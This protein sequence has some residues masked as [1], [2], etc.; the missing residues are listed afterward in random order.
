M[1][2]LQ[3]NGTTFFATLF[4]TVIDNRLQLTHYADPQNRDSQAAVPGGME[5]SREDVEGHLKNGPV[6]I[7]VKDNE[8]GLFH[9]SLLA[10]L[11]QLGCN[12]ATYLPLF[13]A[14]ELHGVMLICARD[15]QTL[16]DDVIK[17]FEQTIQWASNATA[18]KSSK[19]E[20]VDSRSS[21]ELKALNTL[22][23]SVISIDDLQTFYSTV[24]KFIRD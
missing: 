11:K 12:S 19:T 1:T 9:P 23:A 7:Q 6:T 24:H 17:A 2:S 20:P 10:Y 15:G 5:L 16:D 8:E 18:S 4:F 3:A 21:T 13:Q 22:A 14:G